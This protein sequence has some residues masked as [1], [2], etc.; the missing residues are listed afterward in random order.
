M[1]LRS[2]RLIWNYLRQNATEA[3]A[4][5]NDVLIGV[6]SFFRDRASWEQLADQV[7]PLP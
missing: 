6:T 1:G 2:W 5:F 3:T 4:M 7:I